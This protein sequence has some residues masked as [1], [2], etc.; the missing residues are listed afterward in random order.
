MFLWDLYR[1]KGP[2][3]GGMS[4]NY[5]TEAQPRPMGH[6]LALETQH[7]SL[8]KTKTIVE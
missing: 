3:D 6:F 2:V 1:N 8:K 7:V 4:E 5:S